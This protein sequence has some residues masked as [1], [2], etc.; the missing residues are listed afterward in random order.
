MG[1]RDNENI[2]VIPEHVMV[3][4]LEVLGTQPIQDKSILLPW[5]DA[6]K[7]KRIEDTWYK[8]GRLVVTGGLEDKQIILRCYHDAPAYGHPGINKTMQLVE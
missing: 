5:V 1:T 6:H 4:T 8:D 7:L 2:V 3:R